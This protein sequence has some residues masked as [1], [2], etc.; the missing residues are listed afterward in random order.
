MNPRSIRLAAEAKKKKKTKN[1]KTRIEWVLQNSFRR[2]PYW[3]Q[4]TVNLFVKFR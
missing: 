1:N 3:N 4:I 2:D